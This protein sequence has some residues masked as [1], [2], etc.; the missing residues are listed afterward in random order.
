MA[1]EGSW[2]AIRKHG[3][4]TTSALLD[5]H[6]VSGSA[7]LAL[8]S[9]LR[10]QSVPIRSALGAAVI[11]DQKPMNLTA[12]KKCLVGVTPRGWLELLNDRSFFWLTKGRLNRL[13][14]GR[15][16]RK[17]P[18]VVL[19]VDTASLVAAHRDS[20]ELSP[21]NSGSMLYVPQPRGPDL[22][23]SIADYPY[24]ERRRTRSVEDAV[25]ELVVVGGVPDIAQHV[26]CVHD[27]AHPHYS[28]TWRHPASDVENPLNYPWV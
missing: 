16:Y 20:V 14:A 23:K 22:F 11:R 19:T 17:L 8:E 18:Q 2:K 1:A 25:A 15:A 5:L 4:L 13:L 9:Q 24:S 12:M 3:L 10:S 21:I 6:E 7:R 26:V 27:Y 28:E